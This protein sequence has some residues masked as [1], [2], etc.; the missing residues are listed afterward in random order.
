M[1]NFTKMIV[2]LVATAISLSYVANAQVSINTDESIKV[3]LG[4][5]NEIVIIF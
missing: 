5:S 1:N 3:R 2:I 4:L